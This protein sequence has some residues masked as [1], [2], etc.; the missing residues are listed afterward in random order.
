MRSRTLIYFGSL[1]ATIALINTPAPRVVV[2]AILNP[3]AGDAVARSL[4]SITKDLVLVLLISIYFEWVRAKEQG[5][6]LRSIDGKIDAMHAGIRAADV[7]AVRRLVLDSTSPEELVETALDR[8]IE[9]PADKSSFVSMVLSVS[10]PHHDVSVTLRVDRVEEGVLHVSSRFDVTMPRG[11]VLVAATSSP[12][13]AAALGAA[14]PEL[15]EVVTLPRSTPFEEAARLFGERLECYVEPAQGA[16]RRAHFRKVPTAALRKHISLPIGMGSS[17]VS[18]FVADLSQESAEFVRVRHYYRWSQTI[19]E[20]F[21]FW[22]A[23]RP[24]FV[25]TITM[26]MRELVQG[27]GQEVFVQPFLGGVDSLMLDVKEGHLLL[28]LDRWVVQGQGVIAVW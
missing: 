3:E 16:V 11:L 28:R 8:H 9:H 4:G 18:L 19:G 6:M 23:G 22:S 2:S 21:L 25:R 26:D 12:A 24:M 17:D 14:S 1:F 5:E 15:F 27:Q 10:R 7:P 20:H 13:H